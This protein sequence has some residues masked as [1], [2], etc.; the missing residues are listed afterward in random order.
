MLDQVDRRPPG[1]RN[2][3]RKKIGLLIAKPMFSSMTHATENLEG[4]VRQG[5]N[6]LRGTEL[7]QL[8]PKVPIQ[9]LHQPTTQTADRSTA[10]NNIPGATNY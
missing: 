7:P 4:F 9:P 3:T 1:L 8:L 5:P 6:N 10:V 2:L